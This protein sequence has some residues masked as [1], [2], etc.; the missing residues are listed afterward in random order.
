MLD[1]RQFL[2]VR[3]SAQ[4]AARVAS[5]PSDLRPFAPTDADPWDAAKARHL[6]RRVGL[7]AQP[8]DEKALLALRPDQA[9]RQIVAAARDRPQLS[10]PS[11]MGLRQPPSSASQSEKDAYNGANRDAYRETLQGVTNRMLGGDGGPIERLATSLRERMA[12][13]WAG[14]Y[15]TEYRSYNTATWLFGYLRVLHDHALGRVPDVVHAVGTTPAM[16]RYLNGNQSRVGS[17]NE[18]YARELLEL[19]TM[20]TERPDGTATYVQSDVAELARALTGWR[21][22]RTAPEAVYFQ[23]NRFDDGDKTVFGQTGAWGY[24]DVVPLLFDQRPAEIAHFIAGVLYRAF[25]SDEPDAAVV[26]DL[27]VIL[28]AADFEVGPVLETLLASAHFYDARHVG[29][30]VKSPMDL[31]FGATLALGTSSVDVDRSNYLRNQMAQ[32]GQQLF[33]PPDVSGWPGG[34][35]WIDTSTLPERVRR[36]ES[37]VN[38]VWRDL[39]DDV[40]TWPSAYSAR[41]LA[42]DLATRLLPHPPSDDDLDDLAEVLLS[43]TPDYAWDPTTSGGRTRIR[44]YARHLVSLPEFQLR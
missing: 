16:L 12:L 32:V 7:A 22:S 33:N 34:T 38:K 1:R 24:D 36:G 43:G 15:V 27:A 29:A 37:L 13:L 3:R 39:A 28:R 5:R 11:W 20:G 6:A 21:V 14:H 8:N 42:G 25:V 4:P 23:E 18:N 40:A 31:V 44:D 35:S 19:F 17:P 2:R 30:L 9:A 41:G 26:A 10:D